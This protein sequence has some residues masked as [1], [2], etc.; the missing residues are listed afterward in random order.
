MQNRQSELNKPDAL[1]MC[2]PHETSGS[3]LSSG[4]QTLLSMPTLTL[5]S[6]VDDRPDV[7]FIA[8]LGYN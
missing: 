7:R 3:P 2:I 1:A 6:H 4:Y 8:I 5:V